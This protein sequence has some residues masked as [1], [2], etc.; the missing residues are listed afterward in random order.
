MGILNPADVAEREVAQL[1]SQRKTDSTEGRA[2]DYGLQKVKIT[3][4]IRH[5][6]DQY[7]FGL[8]IPAEFIQNS[9]D[10]CAHLIDIGVDERTFSSKGGPQHLPGNDNVRQLLGPAFTV[11]NNETF[12]EQDFQNITNTGES[13]KREDASKTGRFCLGINVAYHL[14]DCLILVTGNRMVAFDPSRIFFPEPF[15]V[16]FGQ[17]NQAFADQFPDFCAPFAIHGITFRERFEGTLFRVPLR[18]ELQPGAMSKRIISVQQLWAD[19]LDD[20][21]AQAGPSLLF[22]KHVR[23]ICVHSIPAES[24]IKKVVFRTTLDGADNSHFLSTRTTILRSLLLN[25]GTGKKLSAGE[26]QANLQKL[27]Q[28]VKKGQALPEQLARVTLHSWKKRVTSRTVWLVCTRVAG[29]AALDMA[30]SDPE[31]LIDRRIPL[32]QAAACEWKDASFLAPIDGRVHCALPLLDERGHTMHLNLYAPTSPDRRKLL[33]SDDPHNRAW[34]PACMEYGLAPAAAMLL[35]LIA[36]RVVHGLTESSLPGTEDTAGENGDLRMSDGS[37]VELQ[38]SPLSGA[39]SGRELQRSNSIN[40]RA[41][42]KPSLQRVTTAQLATRDLP[43]RASVPTNTSGISS[44]LVEGGAA[45]EDLTPWYALFPRVADPGASGADDMIALLQRCI[46]KCVHQLPV[47]AH[48]TSPDHAPDPD[49]GHVPKA[50]VVAQDTLRILCEPASEVMYLDRGALARG[51]TLPVFMEVLQRTECVRLV[52]PTSCMLKGFQ[53]AGHPLGALTPASM[54]K[55]LRAP[56]PLLRRFLLEH[57]TAH[58]T[59]LEY[60]LTD[61]AGAAA[62]PGCWIARTLDDHLRRIAPT[63]YPSSPKPSKGAM[64]RGLPESFEV[65]E[66]RLYVA[67]QEQKPLLVPE[68]AG[69]ILSMAGGHLDDRSLQRLCHHADVVVLDRSPAALCGVLPALLPAT[70]RGAA[71][72]QWL[73]PPELDCPADAAWPSVERMTAI[74]RHLGTYGHL[75]TADLP[76]EWPLL[77]TCCGKLLAFGE[78]PPAFFDSSDLAFLD[79]RELRILQRLGCLVV[80]CEQFSV[81]RAVRRLKRLV[82]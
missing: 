37:I 15:Y 40:V 5:I 4:F 54:C 19:L 7:Q 46:Y 79:G 65:T 50:M 76:Q 71:S 36:H 44:P 31:A 34:T 57:P 14:G 72:L 49:G 9:D 48:L 64:P 6:L 61:E 63:P 74:W 23:T 81:P 60:I 66:D 25:P 30:A 53:L 10:A 21:C 73:Q 28:G 62:V 16:E 13:G 39:R 33:R 41:S 22:L 26:F 11:Y 47:L 42:E 58:L 78:T 52:E 43:F 69:H 29:G 51:P 32:V 56:S 1:T 18:T 27:A 55:L 75:E 67:S 70:W 17:D 12:S 59:C 8:Q 68:L 3:A 77:P 35:Q 2:E 80:D 82:K 38:A 24:K 20:F 45:E